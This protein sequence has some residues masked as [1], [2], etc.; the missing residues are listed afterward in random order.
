MTATLSRAQ[1]FSRGS[2]GGTALLLSGSAVA[3]LA[4]PAAADAI[5]DGDLAYARLLVGAELLASDFYTRAIASK[6]FGGDALKY[7]KRALFNEGE[8]YDALSGVLSGA[9]QPPAVAEDFDF[10]YPKGTFGSKA[11]IV[12][13]GMTLETTFLG[14]YLGAVGALQADALKQPVARIAAS[15]A[16]H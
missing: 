10:L 12:K 9:G 7:L 11:S 3:L 8:H 4:G 1:L 15:E 16:E 5:P 13:L 6:R 2:R 14:A